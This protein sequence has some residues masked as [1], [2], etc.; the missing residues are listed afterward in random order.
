MCQQLWRQL[1]DQHGQQRPPHE[2]QL[3]R[4]VELP[5]LQQQLGLQV[6]HQQQLGH[7][8]DNPIIRGHYRPANQH[9]V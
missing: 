3:I 1:F 8:Q 2:H 9:L 6:E 7:H 4:L 5:R